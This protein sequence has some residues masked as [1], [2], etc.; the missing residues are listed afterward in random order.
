M[1][2]DNYPGLY[3][4]ADEASNKAQKQLLALQKWAA[5]LLIAGS[6]LAMISKKSTVFAVLGAVV[7]LCSLTLVIFGHQKNLQ[8]KW[9]QARALAE[10]IKTA[11]WRLMMSA[12]P[13]PGKGMDQVE[14]Y[15]KL[16]VELLQENK[17]ISEFL[18]T[19]LAIKEQVTDFM[20]EARAGNYIDKKEL[21]LTH[22]IDQ[23]RSWYARKSGQNRKTSHQWLWII[24]SLYGGAVLCLLIR[25][26]CP[27]LTALPIEV[28]A[29]AASSALGWVQIKRYDELSSAYGLAAH[30][31]GI[32]KGRFKSVSSPSDLARFVSDSE[33]AFSREHTQWA[34]RRD[35]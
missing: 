23:Q 25:I 20:L 27:D 7:F 5:T 17:R 34:A 19:D 13:F 1:I 8:S 24:C 6:I 14:A 29:V 11:T 2:D 10:S 12:E 22:R 35:H 3:Q 31:I 4:A 21:Y 32:I 9:Y 18:P 15:R 30:E 28:F 26:A 16:L 33:N